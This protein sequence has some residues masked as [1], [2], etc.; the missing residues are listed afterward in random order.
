MARAVASAKP[1]KAQLAARRFDRHLLVVR[2]LSHLLGGSFDRLLTRVKESDEALDGGASARLAAVLSLQGIRL[3]AEDI[4]RAAR[5]FTRDWAEIAA[6]RE[7]LTQTRWE[8]THFQWLAALFVELYLMLLARDRRAL[9]DALNVYREREL[10]SLPAV[11]PNELNRLALWMATG[12][13]KTLMM[14]LNLRQFL[15]HAKK[16]LGRM[17]E[18]VLLLT[19]NAVLS[20]QHRDEFAC[21]G[22]DP[23][24]L[25]VD[26]E[27]TEITKL[28]LPDP[29]AKRPKEGVSVCTDQYA[30]P[31]L[32][33]VDEGHKGSDGGNDGE[34]AFRARRQALV[35]THEAYPVEGVPGFE[36]EYSATFAQ[37]AAMDSDRFNEYARCTVFDYG[38]RRFH[39]DGFGKTPKSLVAKDDDA[40]DLVLTT[41]MLAFWQQCKRFAED[42]NRAAR[43][44][45]AEPLAVFVGNTVSAKSEDVVTLLAFL[46]RFTSDVDYATQQLTTVLAPKSPVQQAIF[47]ADLDLQAEREMD[48][49]ALHALICETLFGGSGRLAVRKLSKDELGLRLPGAANDRW[50]GSVFVGD[51]AKLEA[52]LRALGT[53]TIEDED[54]VNGSLFARLDH[55]P[56]VR[57][58]IGSRKFIEGWSSFRVGALGLINLGKNA[59]TQVIQ[60]F[61]RGVRLRGIQGRLKRANFLPHL[62]PHPAQVAANETLY[63]FGVKADY[64]QTWLDTMKHEGMSG[65]REIIPISIRS[66]LAELKLQVPGF[67]DA[68]EA[69]FAALPVEFSSTDASDVV[70]DLTPRIS[71]QSGTGVVQTLADGDVK[72]YRVADMFGN[73]LSDETLFQHAIAALKQQD[74]QLLW[75]TKAQVSK[76]CRDRVSIRM[77]ASEGVSRALR[78]RVREDILMALEAALVR[79]VRRARLR[80]LSNRLKLDLLDESHAN[81]PVQKASDGMLQAGYLIETLA[82]SKEAEEALR[83]VSDVLAKVRFRE[84]GAERVLSLISEEI[85]EAPLADLLSGVDVSREIDEFSRPL[86]RLHIPEH[87]YRPL[88]VKAPI[89]IGASDQLSLFDEPA[90]ELRISPPPLEESEARFVWDLRRIWERLHATSEWQG[91]S[92]AILRNLASA[93]VGIFGSE[94]FKPD[95]LLWLI[96]H[97]AEGEA[98][99][100]ALAFVEP[101]GLRLVWPADKIRLLAEEVPSWQLAVP[102]RGYMVT[103]TSEQE[104]RATK[105]S[106][107]WQ[108]DGRGVLFAQ[109]EDGRYIEYILG[110]LRGALGRR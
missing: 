77:L 66:N 41:A 83:K 9:C 38:Y 32:L 5:S 82:P 57:F 40:R 26:L 43:Y 30:G 64:V 18:R 44:R 19:P 69:A 17:P 62:G 108:L 88:L 15:R 39:E 63:V 12:S 22:I 27:I 87:L 36:F 4:E 53:I 70:I 50:C 31:N 110:G 76:W 45:L 47:D 92:V 89:N 90:A 54:K 67:D 86:P 7:S 94:G 13:G 16:L 71:A 79:S 105:P 6:A 28:Y 23:I 96:K 61:G 42:A 73:T 106:F 11:A 33:L 91:H 29:L 84:G 1:N 102:I 52:K 95:F 104:I 60:L 100:Q 65:Q 24:S 46:A 99:T 56:D 10:P 25:G 49:S 103:Q 3:P 59:G 8:L 20:A 21:S 75:V 37:V 14:H 80:F 58:L 35:G 78:E 74:A 2:Y 51:A 107:D 48:A 55:L 93:G 97:G 72:T 81:F 109:G 101:K 98:P 68:Q 85:G 34:S